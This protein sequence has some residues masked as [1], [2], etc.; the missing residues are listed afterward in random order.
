[1]FGEIKHIE[2]RYDIVAAVMRIRPT[3]IACT[4]MPQFNSIQT[5]AGYN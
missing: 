4:C 2:N 5:T 1:M 3:L